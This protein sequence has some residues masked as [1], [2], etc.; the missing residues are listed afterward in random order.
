M[1]NC[2]FDI[3]EYVELGCEFETG[4]VVAFALV[5]EDK[6]DSASDADWSSPTFWQTETYASDI[7]IH[8]KTSGTYTASAVNIP[9]KGSQGDRLAG[10][11]HAAALRVESMANSNYWNDINNSDNYRIVLVTDDYNK[12]LVSEKNVSVFARLDIQDDPNSVVDWLVDITWK[13]RRN[14]KV[15]DAPSGIFN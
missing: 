7:L 5:D 4:R 15:Y 12:I 13:D 3:P 14:P 8:G 6:A 11:D 9:G 1:A 2:R 10:M